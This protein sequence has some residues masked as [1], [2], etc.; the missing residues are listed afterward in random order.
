MELEIM[1]PG[2]SSVGEL[3]LDC[4]EVELEVEGGGYYLQLAFTQQMD[5][6]TIKAKFDAKTMLDP[7]SNSSNKPLELDVDSAVDDTINALTSGDSL[8]AS[9]SAASL[10]PLSL[11][12]PHTPLSTLGSH[13]DFRGME[14]PHT[15]QTVRGRR[16]S[17]SDLK[18]WG[19]WVIVTMVFIKPISASSV[20]S[21]RS[22]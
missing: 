18:V 21:K 6:D 11:P 4:S 14:R 8:A 12:S 20:R 15:S 7:L 1:L 13:H 17:M 5:D 9:K 16:R 19:W 3:D 10:P 2:V 22:R